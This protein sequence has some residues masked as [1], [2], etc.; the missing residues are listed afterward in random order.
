MASFSGRNSAARPSKPNPSSAA[1]RSGPDGG[2]SQAKTCPAMLSDRPVA[3]RAGP[4]GQIKRPRYPRGHASLV[5]TSKDDGS[6]PRPR[7]TKPGGEGSKSLIPITGAGGL[8]GVGSCGAGSG[9][10][11]AKGM[12]LD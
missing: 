11:R 9:S 8:G 10:R 3:L 4:P 6:R 7:P 5:K 1:S 2:W 12:D